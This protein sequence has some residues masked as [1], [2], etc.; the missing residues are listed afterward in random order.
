MLVLHI[1]FDMLRKLFLSE[2]VSSLPSSR[3]SSV[4]SQTSEVGNS[5]AEDHDFDGK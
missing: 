2:D 5:L 4:Q 3:Y 1:V